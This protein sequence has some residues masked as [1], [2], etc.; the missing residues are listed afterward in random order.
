MTQITP[1]IRL[2]TWNADIIASGLG[3]TWDKKASLDIHLKFDENFSFT[4]RFVFQED[5]DTSK[6]ILNKYADAEK[7]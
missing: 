4:V 1:E 6:P 7:T 5:E 2:E 3:I